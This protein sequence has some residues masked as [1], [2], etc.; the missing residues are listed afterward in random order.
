L[1]CTPTRP[2]DHRVADGDIR[3]AAAA[4]R[5]RRR[6]PQS[7]EI[8]IAVLVEARHFGGLAADQGAAGF[9]AAFGDAGTIA[10]AASGSSLPQAK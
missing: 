9:A 5:V 4:C 3:R 8:V 7:R 2:A 10:G 6:R 1:E